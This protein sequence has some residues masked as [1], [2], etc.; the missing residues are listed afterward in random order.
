MTFI[1]TKTH[2]A[3]AGMLVLVTSKPEV[4]KPL[5]P[6][7]KGSTFSDT[8][9]NGLQWSH[10]CRNYEVRVFFVGRV[11]S[12][13][14]LEARSGWCFRF[15]LWTLLGV[16]TSAAH[17]GDRSW[18]ENVNWRV[19]CHHRVAVPECKFPTPGCWGTLDTCIYMKLR[20]C[21]SPSAVACERDCD[22]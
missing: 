8:Y 20:K 22:C 1:S 12:L 9:S 6:G 3:F 18:S 7:L 15:Y 11:V 21:L 17:W 19:S 10:H 16:H 13:A 4:W 5:K 14:E 2:D